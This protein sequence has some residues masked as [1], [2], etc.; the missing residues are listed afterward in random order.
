[1]AGRLEAARAWNRESIEAQRDLVEQAKAKD[2]S[3]SIEW[4]PQVDYT[5]EIFARVEAVGTDSLTTVAAITAKA[6]REA[7]Q[8]EAVKAI[9]ETLLP[10]FPEQQREINN[11]AKALLKKIIRRRI[12]EERARID[13]RGPADRRPLSAAAGLIPAAHGAGLFQRGEAQVLDVT[14]L[15]MPKTDQILD[16]LGNK[17]RKRY[18]HHYDMPPHANG[19][20]GRVGSP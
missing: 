11:A 16:N 13:G 1:I 15:G 2:M 5:D 20:T 10:E 9:I 3:H 12:V 6:E 7:A 18:M 17:D 19:E 8:G 14:T 4:E